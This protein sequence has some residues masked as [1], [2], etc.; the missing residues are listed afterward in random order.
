MIRFGPSLIMSFRFGPFTSV[1]VNLGIF[2]QTLDF[3]RVLS[4]CFKIVRQN[5]SGMLQRFF[6]Y[7]ILYNVYKL[8]CTRSFNLF[9]Y[10]SSVLERE[11]VR[12]RVKRKMTRTNFF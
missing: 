8:I 1:S 11:T 3:I 2:R 10:S 12:V 6:H 7:L 5:V 9:R 4:S